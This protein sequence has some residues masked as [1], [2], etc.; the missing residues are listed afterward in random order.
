MLRQRRSDDGDNGGGGMFE[1][2]VSRQKQDSREKEEQ[3]PLN[4]I[5]SSKIRPTRPVL[6]RHEDAMVHLLT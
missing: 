1:T 6:T 4:R 2:R 5:N 3:R